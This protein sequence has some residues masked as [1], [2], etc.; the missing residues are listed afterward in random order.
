[1][2][3]EH[4]TAAKNETRLEAAA[5]PVVTAFAFHIQDAYN[6]MLEVLQEI[7]TAKLLRA[8]LEDDERDD[9]LCSHVASSTCKRAVEQCGSLLH[10]P[11]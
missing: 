10:D 2:F 6:G 7:E 5:L 11:A 9:E 1:M 3:V 4:C 8:G